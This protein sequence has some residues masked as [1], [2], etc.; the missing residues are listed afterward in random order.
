M[1]FNSGFKGLSWYQQHTKAIST[2]TYIHRYF[3]CN[4]TFE[5]PCIFSHLSCPVTTREPSLTLPR[6]PPSEP[7]PQ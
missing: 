2:L 6:L 3:L 1:G 5:S 4:A 7:L